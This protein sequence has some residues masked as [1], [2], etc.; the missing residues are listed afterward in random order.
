MY[1]SM[2]VLIWIFIA[3][4]IGFF[5]GIF[6]TACVEDVLDKKRRKTIKRLKARLDEAETHIDQIK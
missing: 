5:T 2:E 6:V 1:T 4:G 3:G